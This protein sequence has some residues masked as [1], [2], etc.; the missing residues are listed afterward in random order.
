[1]SKHNYSRRKFLGTMPCVAVGTT[2]L[3]SSLINLKAMNN[4]MASTSMAGGDYKALVCVLL[5]GGNDSFNMIVPRSNAEY[6]EYATVRSNQ[7]L[8]QN[9]LLAI[10][11][12]SGDGREYGLHP[13]LTNMQQMFE[14]GNLAFVNNIGTLVEPTSK[15]GVLDSTSNLPLGLLS[16]SDQVQHWQTAFPQDRTNLGWGGKM[17]DILKSLNDDNGVSMNISLGGNNVFQRGESIV[18]YAINNDGGVAI[19]GWNNPAPFFQLMTEDVTDMMN[20]QYEDIFKESYKGVLKR[21]IESN[22]VFNSAIDNQ[23]PLLTTFS[24]NNLSQDLNMVAQS[25]KARDQLGAKRQI[26]F[27]QLGGFDN[28]DELINNHGQLMATLDTAF[29]EFYAAT[30]ELGVS[31]CV[32]TYTIS[33]FARTLTSNG[34]GTDHAWGGNA[35]VMGG[36]VKGK[37][38][39]GDYPSLALGND[40]ELGGGGVLIPTTSTD[41]YFAELAMWFGISPNDLSQIL[42]NI[43][44]FY[45]VGSGTAPLGF[46]I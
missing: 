11:P 36:A 7:A 45:N 10:N 33:D 2:T 28:H 9:D 43:G 8:A 18:E 21:S 29:A 14:A 27:V 39:Y 37:Q 5:S 30:E 34:N 46:L 22:E 4:I 13:S 15:S 1:M 12:D 44:N 20:R 23:T 42:P 31:D 40:L 24:N 32:T 41:S 38:M 3:F 6:N 35:I 25:I 19:Q 16:H 17:A 26:F